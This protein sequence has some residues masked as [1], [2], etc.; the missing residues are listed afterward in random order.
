[1]FLLLTLW[2][3]REKF[4]P[5]SL[6]NSVFFPLC[7]PS[8][9]VYLLFYFFTSFLLP[10]SVFPSFL[11]SLVPSP[12]PSLPPSLPSSVPPFLR[13]SLPSQRLLYSFSSLSLLFLFSFSSLSLLF[14]FSFSSLSLLFLFSCPLH[15]SPLFSS[16]LLDF[17]PAAF[18]DLTYFS[19][20]FKTQQQDVKEGTCPVGSGVPA[21]VVQELTLGKLWD[22]NV[23]VCVA[24]ALLFVMGHCVNHFH[25]QMYVCWIIAGTM[26]SA[27]N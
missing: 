1:M 13:P 11:P 23:C 3:M 4:C 20:L 26:N 6:F 27:K 18:A 25:L 21:L 19:N 14:L 5:D 2:G 7:I 24:W 17:Q 9:L 12:S 15:S 22:V 10:F 8:L 16:C